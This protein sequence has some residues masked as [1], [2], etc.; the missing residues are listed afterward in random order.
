MQPLDQPVHYG[1]TDR[2]YLDR[3]TTRPELLPEKLRELRWKLNQKAKQEPK[4]RFYALYD[5]IYRKDV[6]EAAWKAV[7]KKGKAAGVDGMR[8]EDVLESSEGVEGFLKAIQEE[9]RGKSYRSSPVRRVHIPKANGKKR[10]LG[11]PTLKD[12][13]VQAAMLLIL[14]PIFEADFEDCSHGFRSGHSAHDALEEIRQYIKSGKV[15]IYDAD[16]SAYFDTIPHDKLMK[17]VEMRV[18]DRSVLGLIRQWL[19]APIIG[20]DENGRPQP[21]QGNRSGTPQGG[22]ISPILANLYLHWFDRAFHFADGPYHWANARLVRYADDFVVLAKYQTRRLSDWIEAKLEGW[23]GLKINRE[24]TKIVHIK[25][26]QSLDFL[27]YSLRYIRDRKGSGDVYLNMEPSLKSQQRHRERIK[28]LTS[29]QRS[30][31]PVEDLIADINRYQNGWREYFKRGYP[32]RVFG[33]LSYHTSERV[34]RHLRR[35]SQRP[36]RFEATES[37]YAHLKKLGLQRL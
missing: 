18:S 30:W 9:L 34:I 23:M 12:R 14:E 35:R 24:K 21:P 3:D 27:G 29:A 20:E 31:L 4:F 15:A 32:A 10:P 8:A 37:Y 17:C 6:L 13:V 22:V 16:L 5:R 36:Y 7:G 28:E 25:E 33:K 1:A 19:Q 2:S 26:G 11:I